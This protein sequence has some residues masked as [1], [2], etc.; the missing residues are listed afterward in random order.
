[1]STRLMA[2]CWPLQMPP[3]AKAVLISLADNANDYGFCYPSI[4]YI[5]ERTCYKKD[6][7]I[8]AI[9]W[10]EQSG[11]L[12]A[13]RTNGRHTTYTIKPK[14][15]TQ[16]PN[17]S[18]RETGR[19]EPPVG[20]NHRSGKPTNQSGKTTKPVG[21][22]DTNRQEPSLTIKHIGSPSASPKET[23]R[24]TRLQKDWQLPD[25]WR[26]EAIR[27]GADQVTAY[28]EAEKFRDYWVGVSGAK[29]LKADWQATWR[30]W[31]RRALENQSRGQSH[32][33]RKHALAEHRAARDFSRVAAKD[34]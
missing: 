4:S 23:S 27:L 15:F 32:A 31:I 16:I 3:T 5:C 26:A 13:D 2:D 14:C 11:I 20:Q 25:D 21:Q 1:M 6:A 7:V 12:L 8:D 29:G 17:I 10:L 18:R 34:F 19:A 33:E 24:G 30:N 22:T 9:K 28:T